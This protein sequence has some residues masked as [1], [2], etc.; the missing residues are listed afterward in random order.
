[1]LMSTQWTVMIEAY[2]IKLVSKY[3]CDCCIVAVSSTCM[4]ECAYSARA[5]SQ[6]LI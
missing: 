4:H 5:S 6:S 1:M 3:F 2:Y